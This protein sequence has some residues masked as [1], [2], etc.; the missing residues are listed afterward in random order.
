MNATCDRSARRLSPSTPTRS[1]RSFYI[2]SRSWV[3]LVSCVRTLLRGDVAAARRRSIVAS[4]TRNLYFFHVSSP[5]CCI[6]TRNQAWPKHKKLCEMYQAAAQPGGSMPPRNTYCG[7]CGAKDRPL[8]KVACCRQ[9][10]CYDP[11]GWAPEKGSCMYNHNRYTLCDDHYERECG[12]DWRTCTKCRDYYGD[13]ETCV[14]SSCPSARL[15]TV[16][17]PCTDGFY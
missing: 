13:L 1:I 15:S 12:G 11:D 7:L 14:L 16:A 3:I 8:R 2:K 6:P 4:N 17:R 9:V 5:P 10:L